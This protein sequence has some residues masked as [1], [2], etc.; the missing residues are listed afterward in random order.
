MAC[1]VATDS[2]NDFTRS[3]LLLYSHDGVESKIYSNDTIKYMLDGCYLCG[4][5]GSNMCMKGVGENKG[6]LE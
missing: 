5:L 1:A 6:Y 4:V 2:I 3:R